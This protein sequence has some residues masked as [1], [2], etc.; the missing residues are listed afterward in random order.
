ME[1]D[2]YSHPARC[3]VFGFSSFFFAADR[4]Q[5]AAGLF[6]MTHAICR[7][8]IHWRLVESIGLLMQFMKSNFLDRIELSP[9]SLFGTPKGSYGYVVKIAWG[10]FKKN[11]GFLKVFFVIERPG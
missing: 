4:L 5:R 7:G 3:E 10:S 2:R 9:Q 6:T 11:Y 1:N 8:E